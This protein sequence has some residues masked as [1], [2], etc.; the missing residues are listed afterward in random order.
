MPIDFT[1]R[2]IKV[3]DTVAYCVR[4]GAKMWLQRMDV[5]QIVPFVRDGK[6]SHKLHGYNNLG[7]KVTVQNTDNTVIIEKPKCPTTT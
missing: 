6:D 7:R 4:R 1:G 5:L 3:G 2:T